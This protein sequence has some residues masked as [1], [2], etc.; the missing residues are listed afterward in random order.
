MRPVVLTH[1]P[2]DAVQTRNVYLPNG[3]NPLTGA[4]LTSMELKSFDRFS[5]GIAYLAER[6]R[7]E[8]LMNGEISSERMDNERKRQFR[9]WESAVLA[10]QQSM[11]TSFIFDKNE[12]SDNE[13]MMSDI[14]IQHSGTD[15]IESASKTPIKRVELLFNTDVN[16]ERRKRKLRKTNKGNATNPS[17]SEYDSDNNE[18]EE[19]ESEEDHEES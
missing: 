13:T 15:G 9:L 3:L 10:E 6:R 16:N 4:I 8:G 12:S 19:K 1:L 17:D 11:Q 2:F 5:M 7:P 18:E 14:N